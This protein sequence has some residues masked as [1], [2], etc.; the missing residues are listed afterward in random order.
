MS[1]DEYIQQALAR[2]WDDMQLG[3]T[4]TMVRLAF[5]AGFKEGEQYGKE[6]EEKAKQGT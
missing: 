4:A 2:Y 1:R 6:E 5:Q 3:I